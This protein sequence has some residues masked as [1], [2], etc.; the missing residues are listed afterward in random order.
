MSEEQEKD[1]VAAEV[2]NLTNFNDFSLDNLKSHF[3][4]CLADDGSISIDKYL[5]GYDELYKFL[6]LLGTVFGWVAT[7]VYNKMETVRGHRKSD[8]A[9]KYETIQTMLEYE[10]KTNMIKPKAKDFTTGSRN[11]LR[12]HWALEY[13]S[14]FLQA[15]PD[16]DANDKCCQTSKEAYKKTLMKNHPWVVQKATLMA[17]NTLPTKVVLIQKFC[18]S[19][20]KEAIEKTTA[21]LQESAKAM[22][23]VYEATQELYKEKNLLNLPWYYN[24]VPRFFRN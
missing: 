1:N 7:E 11:L 24:Y 12:L 22:N 2:R 19:E 4:T 14:S 3:E 5:L 16:L 8:Q 10:I 13:I 6:N 23:K 17:M 15:V 9:A 20:D 18:K 21:A